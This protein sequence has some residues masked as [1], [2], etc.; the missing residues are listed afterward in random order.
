MA[1]AP[2]A[3]F[4]ADPRFQALDPEAQ[5]IVRQKLGTAASRHNNPGNIKVSETTKSLPG[6]AG[7]GSKATDGGTFARFDTPQHGFAAM[8]GLLATNYAD[9]PLGEALKRWSGGGY[10]DDVVQAAGLDPKSTYGALQPAQQIGLMRAMAQREGYAGWMPQPPQPAAPAPGS[11]GI[12]PAEAGAAE[13][14][15]G[16]L[17]AAPAAPSKPLLALT[18]PFAPANLGKSVVLLHGFIQPAARINNALNRWGMSA[19]SPQEFQQ[20]YA[21]LGFDPATIPT[22]IPSSNVKAALDMTSI[23][24]PMMPEA[25]FPALALGGATGSHEVADAVEGIVGGVQAVRGAVGLAMRTPEAARKL[26]ATAAG[27]RRSAAVAELGADAVV[28]GRNAETAD[29]LAQAQAKV[30]ST[31]AALRETLGVPEQIASPEEAANLAG[32]ALTA[33]GR[34]RYELLPG[35]D[36]GVHAIGARQARVTAAKF[37]N[38]KSAAGNL[39]PLGAK[40]GDVMMLQE[41]ATKLLDTKG[42]TTQERDLLERVQALGGGKLT[43]RTSPILTNLGRA[44]QYGTPQEQALWAQMAGTPEGQQLIA[45]NQRALGVAVTPAATNDV[46]SAM[47]LYGHLRHAVGSPRDYPNLGPRGPLK[48]DVY[49]LSNQLGDLIR[50]RVS[51]DPRA[52]RSWDSATRYV[53]E[54]QAPTRAALRGATKAKSP[55]AGLGSL[56]GGQRKDPEPIERLMQNIDPDRRQLY[57]R[58]LAMQLAY[59]TTGADGRVGA[60]SFLNRWNGLGQRQ[61]QIIAAVQ[62]EAAAA[63]SDVIAGK[64]T[65][66]EAAPALNRAVA[67]VNGAIAA[68]GEA[69]AEV[70]AAGRAMVSGES[71]ARTGLAGWQAI[72]AIMGLGMVAT[73]HVG[74][75]AGAGYHGFTWLMMRHPE[76]FKTVAKWMAAPDTVPPEQARMLALGVNAALRSVGG[77]TPSAPTA[78]G[79]PPAV[80][81]AMAPP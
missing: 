24:A 71:P 28:A 18:S 42:L 13:T 6:Y 26:A 7:E 29:A 64:K 17:S 10:G 19:V 34:H 50:S 60:R 65:W 73:G 81:R 47:D 33:A 22:D 3:G 31:H 76:L 78:T 46:P 9:K 14:P 25:Y 59:E 4:E 61:R 38:A 68:L 45:D 11:I 49:K 57:Q 69:Q 66:S 53:L 20:Y 39:A 37:R 54:E 23:L 5:A 55:V 74:Y 40:D 56:F 44:D 2:A 75:A 52:S 72:R 67:N 51:V 27:W 8:H 32:Q 80:G 70:K 1:D 16:P 58:G 43:T 48:N 12:G 41:D 77:A 15:Q 21:H 62:P 63:L 35:E 36:V 79:V 30:A